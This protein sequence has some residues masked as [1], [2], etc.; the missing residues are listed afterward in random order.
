MARPQ[1]GDERREQILAAFEACVMR[2]GLA[3]T[4]LTDVASESGLPRS[5]V[6][7][8]IGNRAEMVD[9]LIDRMVERAEDGVASLRPKERAMTTHDLVDVL[10]TN[11]FTNDVTNT[12]VN[13]LWYLAERDDIM[14]DRLRAMYGRITRMLTTQMEKDGLG[15]SPQARRDTAYAILSL[16]YGNEAFQFLGLQGGRRAAA[17]AAA[18]TLVDTM[19]TEGTGTKTKKEK[20]K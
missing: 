12:V 17:L 8:H 20:Q 2:A 11:T 7:Y 3:K 13:E 15:S 10:F 5:L 19:A 1:M 4:T 18:R 16:T 6:R 14:R 9:L